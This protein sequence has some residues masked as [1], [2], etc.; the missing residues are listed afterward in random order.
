M[1]FFSLVGSAVKEIGESGEGQDV[2]I[3]Q[4]MILGLILLM[5][6]FVRRPLPSIVLI[7]FLHNMFEINWE[8]INA[9]SI[10]VLMGSIVA[11]IFNYFGILVEYAADT[12]FYC[13]ALE[14]ESGAR[15]VRLKELYNMVEEQKALEDNQINNE[16]SKASASDAS[17][18]A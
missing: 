11:V 12:I 3:A 18:Q 6:L 7:F 16:A 9:F 1:A 13:F 2:K 8:V 10:A 17:S 15:Q 4:L 5:L 14:A